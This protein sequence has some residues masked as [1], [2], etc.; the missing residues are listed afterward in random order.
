M[1]YCKISIY[2]DWKF[3]GKGDLNVVIPQFKVFIEEKYKPNKIIL[4]FD[5]WSK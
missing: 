4:I 1:Y 5:F 3:S 2:F